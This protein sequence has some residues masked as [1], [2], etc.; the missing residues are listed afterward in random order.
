MARR[1][2]A[3]GSSGDRGPSLLGDPPPAEVE[4]PAEAPKAK[5]ELGTT[6]HKGLVSIIC[7]EAEKS[8]FSWFVVHR[9][10]L[11]AKPLASAS[12][13]TVVYDADGYGAA[14]DPSGNIPPVLFE[15]CR[16]RSSWTRVVCASSS[17]ASGK[18][19]RRSGEGED[20][21]LRYAET[22]VYLLAW[23]REGSRVMLNL[24]GLY[25]TLGF[26]AYQGGPRSGPGRA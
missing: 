1:R 25:H 17:S 9:A 13:W 8:W 2:G 26:K 5:V 21:W 18:A 24:L 7:W 15:E 20:V 3:A 14:V 22:T 16:A 12:T 19:P 11:E 10:T 4:A 6:P 23:P